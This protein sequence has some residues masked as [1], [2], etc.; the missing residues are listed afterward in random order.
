MGKSR[1]SYKWK[2]KGQKQGN[3]DY[4]D[5]YQVIEKE[6]KLFE[7]SY[8]D[9]KI[10]PEEEWEDF[11]SALRREL[12]STFRITGTRS[13]AQ[14]LLRVLKNDFV[15]EAECTT[16]EEE[17]P[18]QCL[19]WYPDELA[20]ET[21]TAKRQIR[22]SDKM[23]QLHK[24]LVQETNCGAITRQ[25]AVSMIPPLFMD[26]QP[27]HKVLDMC[28][29]PGSKTAQLIEMMNENL[30]KELPSG[31][32]VANDSNNKR[33]YMLVHQSKRLQSA[34]CMVTN[35]DASVYPF[36]T[37]V[38]KTTGCREPL[39]FDRILC[40]VPCSGDGTM[41]KNPQI[42]ERWTPHLGVSLH[43][44]QLKILV[45]GLELLADGGRVVYSTCTMN[46]L[47]DEAVIATAVKMSKGAV[48]VVDVSTKLPHLRRSAGLTKWKVLNKVGKEIKSFD[49][50]DETTVNEGYKATMFPP[51]EEE[52]RDINLE[53]CIRVY[54][55]QQDTGG[56]F[57]A[58]LKKKSSLPWR[59][60][61]KIQRMAHK[62]MLP[63]EF[64]QKQ[65]KGSANEADHGQN[66][67]QAEEKNSELPESDTKNESGGA[68]EVEVSGGKVHEP[69]KKK[70]KLKGYH[71]DPFIF[72]KDD[73]SQLGKILKFLGFPSS[74]PKNQVL[75]RTTEGIK[76][77][78]YFVSEK[79]K[80]IMDYNAESLKII[81][82]GLKIFTRCSLKTG[83]T[84]ACNFRLT[85][86]GLSTTH[87]YVGRQ[88][89]EIEYED[90]IL[91]LNEE[92]LKIEKLS[93]ASKAQL[94]VNNL[95]C[96]LW[97]F[98]PKKQATKGECTL[99][100]DIWM[101]GHRGKTAIRC[102]MAKAERLH[103]LR[104]L[105]LPFEHLEVQNGKD[106]R[107]ELSVGLD[108][109]GNIEEVEEI[110]ADEDGDGV[111]DIDVVEEIE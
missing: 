90:L 28:A 32:V 93:A 100:N 44:L 102:M 49:D 68:I 15:S 55:H 37:T 67:N 62:K 86:E 48:E 96:I 59:S 39:L 87:R 13:H 6:N 80:E 78:V 54:P 16:D 5:S 23:K 104:I 64:L 25:E 71:E 81:N 98:D 29:A 21:K 66:L 75:V 103:F 91:L 17:R 33:C 18:L 95:G 60:A 57:I 72:L 43:R 74:F 2:K 77:H 111:R 61:S 12:P 92:E 108:T 110:K 38:N 85:Q 19:N 51:T 47:E 41:R 42:W 4:A 24:F 3:E 76:R 52:N 8:K 50:L 105:G 20:W 99:A 89:V 73:D 7:A 58:V 26:I 94:E 107:T 83:D 97:H 36:L 30:D 14:N 79:C 35:H 109:D 22:K 11:M 56:F 106:A 31:V 65:E 1:K 9:Q 84:E 70:V 10:I 88:K 45:R 46:P 82:S 53:R 27:Q 34:C 69:P 101:C 63:W 40:D